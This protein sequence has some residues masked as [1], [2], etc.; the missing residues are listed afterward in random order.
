[1]Y[2]KKEKRGE[3]DFCNIC[4]RKAKLTWD[5]APP[6]C[7]NNQCS[8]RTNSWM[9][10]IPKKIGYEK[11]YQNGIRYRFLCEECNNKLLEI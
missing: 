7:C 6:K 3:Y 11:Q 2:Y 8:I 9:S 10:G 5:Q 1:M 4:G